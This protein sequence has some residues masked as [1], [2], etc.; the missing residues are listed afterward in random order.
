MQSI[1][2]GMHSGLGHDVV[3]RLDLRPRVRTRTLRRFR[4]RS[5]RGLHTRTRRRLR[6]RAPL[7]RLQTLP[8]R[9]IR[10]G[11]KGNGPS[12]L[13]VVTEP[14]PFSPSSERE[15][16]P[17]SRRRNETGSRRPVV[18]TGPDLFVQWSGRDRDQSSCRRDGS[19]PLRP[20]F[21]TDSSQSSRRRNGT[22]PSRRLRTWP[23][24]RPCTRLRRPLRT[25]CSVIHTIAPAALAPG[26]QQRMHRG[27]QKSLFQPGYL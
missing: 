26:G 27:R 18:G 20:V 24:L 8:R 7:G 5:R 25:R 12:R 17:S 22:R 15:R 11:R 19:R 3:C 9:R 14:V 2:Q 13:S 23:D 6:T 21:G 4:I 1:R 10:N 16:S